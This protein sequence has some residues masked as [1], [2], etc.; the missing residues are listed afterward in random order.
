MRVGGSIGTALLTVILQS[1][2]TSAGPRASADAMAQGFNVTFLWVMGITVVAL[3]PTI[4]LIVAER[5]ARDE[6]LD[7][8]SQAT[9]EELTME[10]A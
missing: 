9:A 10:A 3:L 1:Q 2:L 6:R 5:R 4:L 7:P 8:P